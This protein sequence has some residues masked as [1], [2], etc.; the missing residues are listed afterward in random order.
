LPAAGT[1]L[2]AAPDR[3]LAACQ[4]AREAD[5]RTEATFVDISGRIL[6]R[7]RFDLAVAGRWST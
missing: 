1:P 6:D 5:E 7:R 2:Q 3:F 4:A